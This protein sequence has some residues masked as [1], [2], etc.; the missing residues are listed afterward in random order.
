[1]IHLAMWIVSAVI[2]FYAGCFVIGV[3]GGILGCI[4]EGIE[5][6]WDTIWH[7]TK[8]RLKS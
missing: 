7:P 3:V 1:M 5:H 6:Q 4:W 2:V 8:R